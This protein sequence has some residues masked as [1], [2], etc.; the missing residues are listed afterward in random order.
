MLQCTRWLNGIGLWSWDE[1]MKCR[2]SDGNIFIKLSRWVW[3]REQCFL[4]MIM[5]LAAHRIIPN[6]PTRLSRYKYRSTKFHTSTAR[7]KLTSSELNRYQDQN[8]KLWWNWY[9]RVCSR[10]FFL[11]HEILCH[12]HHHCPMLFQPLFLL[13]LSTSIF[14]I[15]M[16]V[17]LEHPELSIPESIYI[18]ISS[19]LHSEFEI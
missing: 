14:I 2:T 3:N 1:L 5:W 11:I 17:T 4:A 6:I 7:L 13:V 18:Q 16:S 15:H 10:I 9:A 8:V 19:K 12:H